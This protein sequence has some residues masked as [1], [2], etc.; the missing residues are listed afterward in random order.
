MFKNVAQKVTLLAIDTATNAPKTGDAANLTAYVSKDDGAVT[1]L[2]DTS[3]TEKDST[4][5]AGLY[6]FDLSQ[7]ET[8]A[9]KLVFSGKSTTANVKIVP[10]T[11]YTLPATLSRVENI[12]SAAAGSAGGLWILGTNAAAATRLTG[13]LSAPA[14]QLTGGSSGAA[15]LRCVG[16]A[17]NL[18]TAGAGISATGGS[19]SGG[20]GG[21]GMLLT[22]GTGTVAD[23]VSLADLASVLAVTTKLDTTWVLDGGVYQFT[24]NALELGPGGAGGSISGTIV[25]VTL[26]TETQAVGEAQAVP[27]VAYQFAGFAVSFDLTDAAGLPIS[28][29]GKVVNFNVY[30]LGG[31]KANVFI[32]GTVL[33]GVTISGANSN[34]VTVT[35]TD[36]RT[37]T[38]GT[39][40]YTVRN[41]T[42]DTVLWTG[43]WTVK[44]VTDAV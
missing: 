24:A 5:A 12:P 14:L 8:N 4:N 25:N 28:L 15:G 18:G 27:L 21:D 30:W 11:V 37:A 16:G 23:G 39:W 33:G 34:R 36:A 13:S 44:E 3:A 29:A 41:M 2:T 38:A 17:N 42:D 10:L 40:G 31:S 43:T 26:D 1:V 7:D 19:N 6:D 35:M 22:G 20:I 9:D 32:L